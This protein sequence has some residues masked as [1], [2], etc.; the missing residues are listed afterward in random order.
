MKVICA[1]HG[2]REEK[3]SC[4]IGVS[5]QN[6]NMK[7]RTR[8][9]EQRIRE[10]VDNF[11]ALV[12]TGPRQAGKTCLLE[13]IGRELFPRIEKVAFDAP[14]DVAA[15]RRDPALFFA[16]HPGVLFLDE[17]QHVPDLFPYLKKEVDRARGVF[18]FFISGSQSFP[19]MRGVSESL[20]GRAGVLDL[21]PFCAQEVA[22]VADRDGADETLDLL[23][24]P[25]RLNA[26]VG[27]E[28]GINDRDHV[29]PTMLKG[30]FPKVAILHAGPQWLESYRRTYIQRDIRELKRVND[31]GRFD[32]FTVLCAGLTGTVLNKADLSRSIGIDNKTVDDWLSLLQASYQ[33]VELPPFFTNLTK[34]LV[35]RHKGLFADI[36][37]G[38]HL[39][40]IRDAHGLLNAPH[41]GHLFET[42]VIMEIRKLYGH[43]GLPWDGHFWRTPDGT[44][45]DLVLPVAG[46]VVPIEVK[47]AMHLRPEDYRGL[48]A[49]MELYGAKAPKGILVSMHPRVE[50]VAANIWNLP[51]GLLLNG[52]KSDSVGLNAPESQAGGQAMAVAEGRVR[53]GTAV[54]RLSQGV[55]RPKRGNGK[56]RRPC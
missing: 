18:R 12:V 47:H 55:G 45:V 39:Q 1:P 6:C 17:V 26:Y 4:K 35:K 14:S 19:V 8:F 20:A 22:G 52:P 51:L 25:D 13:R 33:F 28:F 54:K 3:N 34:R 24:N 10:W 7:Y 27:K 31:L 49:F 41:F 37:L 9:L 32:R 5:L 36:G 48:R 30:G 38:L 56:R 50:R 46:R 16:N 29:A 42:F 15:F 43:A 40:G 11:E 23:E 53:Y 21:W 44:E 2:S